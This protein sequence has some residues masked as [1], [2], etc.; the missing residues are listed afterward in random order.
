MAPY[1]GAWWA[2]SESRATAVAPLHELPKPHSTTCATK[3]PHKEPFGKAF[4]ISSI[5][6]WIIPGMYVGVAIG[7]KIDAFS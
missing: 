3:Q 7:V 5:R 4:I 1:R 2:G 6:L